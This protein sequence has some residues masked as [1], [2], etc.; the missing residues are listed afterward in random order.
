VLPAAINSSDICAAAAGT[1]AAPGCAVS[2]SPPCAAAGG[3][4]APRN[5]WSLEGG[6]DMLLV[7]LMQGALSYP[8]FPRRPSGVFS[9]GGGVNV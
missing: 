3:S 4:W 2:Q 5:M 7:G 1:W 6:M 8:L 9:G